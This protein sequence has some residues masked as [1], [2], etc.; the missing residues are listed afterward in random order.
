MKVLFSLFCVS[1]LS[2]AGF[3]QSQLPRFVVDQPIVQMT[4]KSS[5]QEVY[6]VIGPEIRQFNLPP[7]ALQ[8]NKNNFTDNETFEAYVAVLSD[9]IQS[10]VRIFW[11][12]ISFVQPSETETVYGWSGTIKLVPG[13]RHKLVSHVVDNQDRTGLHVFIAQM[14]DAQSGQR[15][16][17]T[18]ASYV[19]RAFGQYDTSYY[20]R[21][22]SAQLINSQLHLSGLFVPTSMG[23]QLYAVVRGRL[24]PVKSSD[25]SIAV[26][27]VGYIAPGI[28]DITI[29]VIFPG[30]IGYDSVTAPGALK[31]FLPRGGGKG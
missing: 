6:R 8:L 2:V 27:D 24:L 5:G 22:D 9:E 15:I 13:E 21:L 12:D 1:F 16:A 29:L 10:P 26:A 25:F 3:A 23:F 4:E 7:I 18:G 28:Y 11:Q 30:N 31:I 19:V 14:F 20:M 17:Y